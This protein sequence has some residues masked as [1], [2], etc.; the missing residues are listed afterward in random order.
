MLSLSKIKNWHH[1][2]FLVLGW[3]AF[4]DFFDELVVLLCELEGDVGIVFG[5]ISML[6]IKL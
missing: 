3:V 2:R 5:G 6:R 4:E 1:G